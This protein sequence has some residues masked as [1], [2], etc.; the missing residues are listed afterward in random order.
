MSVYS[1]RVTTKSDIQR[2]NWVDQILPLVLRPYARLMRLDRPIGTWL[3]LLPCWWS[4]ALG[5]K[6]QN[7]S[8]GLWELSKFYLLFTL[9]AIVMRGAGCVINDIWDRKI[10]RM[11]SRTA[12]RPI[13]SGSIS[14]VRALAF[15]L[16]LLLIGLTI[17]SQL[18]ALCWILGFSVLGL[19][20]SYPL[21]KR[22]IYWPQ[23]ILGLTFIWGAL[24]GWA[25][26]IGSLDWLCLLLYLAGINWT[27]GYDTIYAHQDKN[28][29]ILIG[30]KSSAI[31]LGSKTRLF[32]LVFYSLTIIILLLTGYI[33]EFTKIFYMLLGLAAAQLAWQVW[34]I[35]IDD[36]KDC[37]NKFKSNRSFGLLITVAIFLG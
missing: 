17:L 27:L 22:I 5:W 6:Y 33:S 30:I 20:V 29:D 1:E 13:A 12:D 21:F 11:V 19:V 18:N 3:L 23:F 31:S 34:Q 25:A 36:P 26:I 24:M 2:D 28:D 14:V 32:L 10:D 9:G 4:L 35:D 15:L 16:I 8:L 7:E 37:L